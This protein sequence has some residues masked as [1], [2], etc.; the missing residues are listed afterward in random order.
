MEHL[1]R[2]PISCHM[3]R[4][5]VGCRLVCSNT[6]T[7][8]LTELKEKFGTIDEHEGFVIPNLPCSVAVCNYCFDEHNLGD[9][10]YYLYHGNWVCPHCRA[11]CAKCKSRREFSNFSGYD[12]KNADEVFKALV[13][14]DISSLPQVK[15]ENTKPIGQVD[16]ESK[17]ITR[18]DLKK[19]EKVE[20]PRKQ[21]PKPRTT[22]K[23]TKTPTK[24]VK[25][26]KLDQQRIFDNACILAKYL[27]QQ[28]HTKL[29]TNGDK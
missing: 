29:A 18:G 17:R 23:Q 11:D 6:F 4:S 26:A 22:K 28:A 7:H 5:S 1:G 21:P 9:Y 19:H 20:T 12:G 25:E 10:E 15:R 13:T 2:I 27:L 14:G 3:C 16:I 8:N 24:Q